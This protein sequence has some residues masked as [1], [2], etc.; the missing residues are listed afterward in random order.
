MEKEKVKIV[1]DQPTLEGV[2]NIQKFLGFTN[3]YQWFIKDFA[4]IARSLHDLV[5]KDQKW[6]WTERQKKTFQ[7]Q[8]KK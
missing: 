4:T 8:I 1:L 7:A 3:Y 5:K 2:K 6:N